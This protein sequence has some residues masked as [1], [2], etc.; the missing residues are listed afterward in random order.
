MGLVKFSPLGDRSPA[1]LDEASCL[2]SILYSNSGFLPLPELVSPPPHFVARNPSVIP[3]FLLEVQRDWAAGS[4]GDAQGVFLLNDDFVPGRTG[5][6]S[7]ARHEVCSGLWCAARV[8]Q[9]LNLVVH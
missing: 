2:A 1:A 6:L 7:S 9:Y 8:R 4:N 3:R 5:W